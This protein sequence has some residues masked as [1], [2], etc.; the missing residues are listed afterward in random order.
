MERKN[1]EPYFDAIYLPSD[2]D[3]L[4]HHILN[5]LILVID[6]PS[7]VED[8]KMI[9]KFRIC[10]I[11]MY[12]RNSAHPDEYVHGHRNQLN[13]SHF[14]FHRYNNGSYKA[15]TYK[16]LDITLGNE[17][18][19]FGIL[20][21][22]IEDTE[23]NEFIEGPCRVVNKLLDSFGVENVKEFMDKFFPGIDQ[24][25]IFNPLLHLAEPTADTPF[26]EERIFRGPRIGLS[27]KYPEYRNRP[28]RYAI[29][30]QKLKKE[31]KQLSE[32]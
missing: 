30:T 31:R 9:K 23:T 32:C 20:I 4:A 13:H 14:Y 8:G 19:Y 21:R 12:Y 29:K 7:S 3:Q 15:G 6:P 5:D 27:A 24:I 1:E 22:S 2:F 17:N 18:L 16:G 26:P 11:E 28:Y 10:E 25:D